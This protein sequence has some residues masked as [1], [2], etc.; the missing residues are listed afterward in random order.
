MKE[1]T[2]EKAVRKEKRDR[3]DL[4]VCRDHQD[5]K[6]NAERGVSAVHPAHRGSQVNVEFQV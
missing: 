6:A 3:R 1:A 4:G 2:K 5:P